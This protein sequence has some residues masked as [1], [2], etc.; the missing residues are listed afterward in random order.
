MK[1]IKNP[2]KVEDKD[3]KRAYE[4][5]LKFLE[6]ERYK[7]EKVKMGISPFAPTYEKVII[8]HITPLPKKISELIELEDKLQ[9]KAGKEVGIS[10]S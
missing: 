5:A 3:L 4:L 9:K 7:I 8:I 10:L 1:I 6:S 2:A